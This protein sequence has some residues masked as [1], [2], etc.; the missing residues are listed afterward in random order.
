MPRQGLNKFSWKNAR[1]SLKGYDRDSLLKLVGEMYR[2]SPENRDFLQARLMP[3]PDSATPFK[4]RLRATLNPDAFGKFDYD[5][6]SAKRTMREFTRANSDPEAIADLMIYAVECGNRFTLNCGDIDE[7]FYDGLIE[8]YAG[9]IKKVLQLPRD[10]RSTYRGRLEKIMKSSHGIGWGYHDG[11][12]DLF[13]KAF[14]E[15]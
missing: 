11:L 7:E 4:K 12:C 1:S 9:A 2:L 8:T 13:D 5:L 6:A 15:K 10:D 14:P 3:D